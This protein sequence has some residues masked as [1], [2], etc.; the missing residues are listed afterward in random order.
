MPL[1]RATA[2]ARPD[3][4]GTPALRARSQN[5]EAHRPQPRG[6]DREGWWSPEDAAQHELVGR[7]ETARALLAR[8]S[9][10]VTRIPQNKREAEGGVTVAERGS[11]RNPGARDPSRV[12]ARCKNIVA[13]RRGIVERVRVADAGLACGIGS[14]N[15]RIRGRRERR[16]VT[17]AGSGSPH[18]ARDADT[19][20][21]AEHALRQHAAIEPERRSTR[22]GNLTRSVADR[23]ARRH[24]FE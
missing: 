9:D 23:D 14:H 18:E 3:R 20:I 1:A 11:A 19:R 10:S 16:I 4:H 13:G 7:I 12:S 22:A 6:R 2:G 15:A 17:V 8:E 5:R 24:V 21:V